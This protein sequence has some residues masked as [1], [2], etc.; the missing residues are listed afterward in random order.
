MG[1]YTYFL[2]MQL[3][4]RKDDPCSMAGIVLSILQIKLIFI[5]TSIRKVFC[6]VGAIIS[7]TSQVGKL[8][9]RDIKVLVGE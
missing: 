3:P 5:F 8:R 1:S 6:N 7:I 2:G 4:L 9:F